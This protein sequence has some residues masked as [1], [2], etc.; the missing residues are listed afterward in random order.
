MAVSMKPVTSHS[1]V[2]VCADSPWSHAHTLL[3]VELY[4]CKHSNDI[5]KGA[6]HHVKAEKAPP[7]I[8]P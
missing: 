8:E 5:L 4:S 6:M 3:Y 1:S 7:K 2:S